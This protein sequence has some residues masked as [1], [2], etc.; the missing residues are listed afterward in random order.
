MERGENAPRTGEGR[1]DVQART[2]L[3][4]GGVTAVAASIAVVT[5]VALT[6]T[7]ALTDSR[8]TSLASE[9]VVV[10]SATVPSASPRATPTVTSEALP[11]ADVEVVEAPA[12]LVVD[13]SSGSQEARTPPTPA[14][15]PAAQPAP[16]TAA[17]ATPAEIEPAIAA[18]KAAGSWDGL[19]TWA[20]AHGWTAARIDALVARLDR[21]MAAQAPGADGTTEV[22]EAPAS[23]ESD[24]QRRLAASGTDDQKSTADTE[25]AHNDR[26][27]AHAGSNVGNGNGAGHDA[28]KDQSRNSPDK[29]D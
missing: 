20:L 22:G 19:R 6:N 28:K 2:G 26:R 1:P 21:E 7:L 12:P 11:P 8:G 13:N 25:P 17:P 29:R 3:V 27:P 14:A 16:D 23:T 9:R 4:I 10:P 15:P 24:A 5:A 18:A